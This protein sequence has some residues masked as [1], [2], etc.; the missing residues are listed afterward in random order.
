MDLDGSRLTPSLEKKVKAGHLL[1]SGSSHYHLIFQHP[2]LPE[3]P[4]LEM[5]AEV[6]SHA[7]SI[8]AYSAWQF[9]K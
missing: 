8:P 6:L 3:I 1:I 5:S 4:A 7:G 9:I 2:L